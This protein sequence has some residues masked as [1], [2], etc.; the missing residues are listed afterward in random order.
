MTLDLIK[1]YHQVPIMDSDQEKTAFITPFANI[2]SVLC[3]LGKSQP[4]PVSENDVS[5]DGRFVALY[6]SLSR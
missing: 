1:W 2:N 6:E 5:C 3:H 4:L